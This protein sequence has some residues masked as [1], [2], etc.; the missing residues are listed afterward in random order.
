ML[1]SLLQV[2]ESFVISW[3]VD[4]RYVVFSPPFDVASL[5]NSHYAKTRSGHIFSPYVPDESVTSIVIDVDLDELV[6][7]AV[8]VERKREECGADDGDGATLEALADTFAACALSNNLSA[9]MLMP[10]PTCQSSV[11]PSFA[12]VSPLNLQPNTQAKC[13]QSR[14]RTTL[15]KNE[16]SGTSGCAPKLAD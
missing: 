5:T 9:P 7:C 10:Q 6:L 13:R 3:L 16:N 15:Q 8:E 11:A 14:K 1:L 12:Q 4:V 2:L